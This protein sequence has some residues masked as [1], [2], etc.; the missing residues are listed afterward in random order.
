[1]STS[2][3]SPETISRFRKERFL[4]GYSEDDFRDLVVRPLMYRLGYG[5]GRDLCGPTE[6]GR[7]AVFSEQDRLGYLK[8]VAVQ[9]KKGKLNLASEAT[10]NLINVVAQLR[11]ALAAPISLIKD[12]RKCFP[13]KVILCASGKI[14]DAARD[15]IVDEIKDPRIAFLDADELIPL[16]DQHFPELWLDIDVDLFPYFKAL[17][18]LVEQ[19]SDDHAIGESAVRG[20]VLATAA[21]DSAFV[22]LS[23]FRNT[24]RRRVFR[25]QVTNVPAIEELPIATLYRRRERRLLLCGDAGSGKSTAL[26]RIAYEIVNRGVTTEKEYRVPVL[27]RDSYSG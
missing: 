26:L 11:T 8:L 9:T 1:M 24:L 6:K 13:E 20:N 15:Y 3:G 7:D 27:V 2:I 22:P 10:A 19:K 12:K 17:R 21:S 25:G 16:I 18:A 5:D 23:A 4:Q 14:N